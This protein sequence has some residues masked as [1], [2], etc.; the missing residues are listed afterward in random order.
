MYTRNARWS[1]SWNSAAEGLAA[2]EPL[3]ASFLGSAVL[4]DRAALLAV[5]PT[6]AIGLRATLSSA[7]SSRTEVFASP[8]NAPGFARPTPPTYVPGRAFPL[9]S[10]AAV[11]DASPRRQ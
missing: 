3:P 8:V 11:P 6:P 5:V 4:S 7:P 2:H 10:A 1:G 9:A